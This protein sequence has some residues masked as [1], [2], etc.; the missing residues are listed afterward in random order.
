LRRALFLFQIDDIQLRT[1][2]IDY[3]VMAFYFNEFAETLM[4][5][6]RPLP[7]GGGF[8]VGDVKG[9]MTCPYYESHVVGCGKFA[10][11][12]NACRRVS[13]CAYCC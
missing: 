10:K 13:G 7:V 12:V 9:M 1:K 6:N 2:G 11:H 5:E 3:S 8:E 4:V